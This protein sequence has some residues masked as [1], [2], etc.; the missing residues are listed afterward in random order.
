VIEKRKWREKRNF[1]TKLTLIIENKDIPGVFTGFN[2]YVM[3][4]YRL[5]TNFV[6]VPEVEPW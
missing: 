1:T 4:I 2:K 3:H 6:H 5:K